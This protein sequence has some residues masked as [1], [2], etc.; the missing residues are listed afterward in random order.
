MLENITDEKLKKLTLPQ[1]NTLCEEARQK[2]IF[3]VF[4]NGG[5]LSSN[6]GSVVLSVSLH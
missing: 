2:I 3:T 1:L 4:R 6:L 5:H